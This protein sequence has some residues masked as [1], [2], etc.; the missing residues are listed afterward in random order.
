MTTSTYEMIDPFERPCRLR[1][2]TPSE[3]SLEMGPA[4]NSLPM[5]KPLQRSYMMYFPAQSIR[6]PQ[7]Q[8][9]PGQVFDACQAKV[10]V[11]YLLLGLPELESVTMNCIFDA[12][13]A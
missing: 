4:C 2:Q 1:I 7:Q 6:R 11:G 3:L 9:R 5:E 13:S 10:D 8:L 12:S